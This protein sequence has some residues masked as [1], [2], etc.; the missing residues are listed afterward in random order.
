MFHLV[1]YMCYQEM[2]IFCFVKSHV[3]RAKYSTYLTEINTNSKPFVES[4]SEVVYAFLWYSMTRCSHADS[5]I[6][7]MIWI[8]RGRL[9]VYLNSCSACKCSWGMTLLSWLKVKRSF[10]HCSAWGRAVN[11]VW[12]HDQFSTMKR[13]KQWEYTEHRQTVVVGQA[14]RYSIRVVL[15]TSP[16]WDNRGLLIQA[17]AGSQRREVTWSCET[18]RRPQTRCEGELWMSSEVHDF[19]SLWYSTVPFVLA[20]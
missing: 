15:V 13:A 4:V 12:S 20:R 11:P 7:D 18:L 10:F 5:H 16:M 14:W 1:L 17:A 3:W 9:R 19:N 8:I 2:Y 6:V